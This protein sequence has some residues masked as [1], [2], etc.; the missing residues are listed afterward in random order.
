MT[1]LSFHNNGNDFVVTIH[2]EDI[3]IRFKLYYICG[4]SL[5]Q[6]TNTITRLHCINKI[7]NV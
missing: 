1:Y 4:Q 6:P 5:I 3:K 2:W 7:K